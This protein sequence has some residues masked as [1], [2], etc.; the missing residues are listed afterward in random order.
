[1]ITTKRAKKIQIEFNVNAYVLHTYSF[2]D[3]RMCN[4]Y[5]N[6]SS[7]TFSIYRIIMKML[8]SNLNAIIEYLFRG[9]WH[10]YSY[11]YI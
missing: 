6:L 9:Y 11:I 2:T 8:Y 3:I 5:I 1:M 10:L 7:I 4:V